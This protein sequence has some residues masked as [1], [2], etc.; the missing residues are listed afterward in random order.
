MQVNMKSQEQFDNRFAHFADNAAT[1]KIFFT[2][3][4]KKAHTFLQHELIELTSKGNS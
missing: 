4:I 2:N 1:R 3:K